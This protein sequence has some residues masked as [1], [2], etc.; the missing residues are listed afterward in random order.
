MSVGQEV[1]DASVTYAKFKDYIG[2]GICV[3]IGICSMSS[4]CSAVASYIQSLN[5]PASTDPNSPPEKTTPIWIGPGMFCCGVICIIVAYFI[6]N[7]VNS[8]KYN[9]LLAAQGALD[10]VGD[11]KTLLGGYHYFD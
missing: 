2:V 9:G 7:M 5:K 3:I 1:Y 4:G 11:V 10:F 6:Y 8:N